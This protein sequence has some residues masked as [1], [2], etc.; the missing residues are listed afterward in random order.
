MVQEAQLEPGKLYSIV[1]LPGG[2]AGKPVDMMKIE[3]PL[4]GAAPQAVEKLE[5][6]PSGKE[7]AIAK[8]DYEREDYELK[9]DTLGDDDANPPARPERKK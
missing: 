4:S 5:K 2:T 1:V 9:L 7:K 6:D 8:P 3:E